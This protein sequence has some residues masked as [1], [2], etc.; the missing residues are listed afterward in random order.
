MDH[1]AFPPPGA[2]VA[3]AVK[4]PFLTFLKKKGLFSVNLISAFCLRVCATTAEIHSVVL[5]NPLSGLSSGAWGPVFRGDPLGRHGGHP[6]L[7]TP[8]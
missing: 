1:R 6:N 3:D 4:W 7:Q 2:L 5:P 8:G